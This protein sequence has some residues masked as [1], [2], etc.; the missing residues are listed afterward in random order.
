[1]RNDMEDILMVAIVIVF[2]LVAW[3]Y[4]AGCDRI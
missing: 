4:T 1:M 2:F 3:A